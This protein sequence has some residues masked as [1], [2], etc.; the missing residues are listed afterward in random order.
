MR[1]K[2]FYRECVMFLLLIAV[3]I[4]P[5]TPVFGENFDI[6]GTGACEPI[7]TELARSFNEANPGDNV[8]VPPSTGSGGGIT[9]VL[10][11]QSRLARVARPLK[12]AELQQG[13]STR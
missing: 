11:G 1:R 13:L 10:K 2:G 7:L 4:I 12:E 8:T 6:P 9:A 3:L 5:A